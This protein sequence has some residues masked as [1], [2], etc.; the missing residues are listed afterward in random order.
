MNHLE[1]SNN[2][3]KVSFIKQVSSLY[4]FLDV[5]TDDFITI[6]SYKLP[7]SVKEPLNEAFE[8]MLTAMRA[9]E[10]SEKK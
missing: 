1:G 3:I 6:A 10:E 5:V 7:K 4:D 2:G 9:I 8:S